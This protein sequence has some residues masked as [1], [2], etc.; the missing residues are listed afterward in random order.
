MGKV[1][2]RQPNQTIIAR[3]SLR[4]ALMEEL[5]VDT[6]SGAPL[7]LSLGEFKIPNLA[8]IPPIEAVLIERPDPVGP[9]SA[10]ALGRA[11]PGARGGG[12]RQRRL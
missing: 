2:M 1:I 11:T 7:A 9:F 4:A 10:K 5:R 6:E 12:H 8:D 3:S